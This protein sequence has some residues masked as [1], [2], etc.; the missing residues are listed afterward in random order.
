[1]KLKITQVSNGVILER[2]SESNS[3]KNDM[4]NISVIDF[5]NGEKEAIRKLVSYVL[6]EC[7][8]YQY[9]KYGD[10]NIC[11]TFGNKG[12]KECDDKTFDTLIKNYF[13][14]D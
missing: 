10:N 7:T 3:E 11:L 14:G 1:M 4:Q 2:L 9:N 12:H 13:I 8:D 6:T 5:D